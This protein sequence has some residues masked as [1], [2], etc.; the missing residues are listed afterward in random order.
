MSDDF[1][2]RPWTEEPDEDAPPESWLTLG[3]DD[4]LHRIETLD[5]RESEDVRL[6]EVVASDRHFFIRQEAAKRIRSRKLLFPFEDD[7]HVGQILVRH[8][9]RRE[10]L[11]YLERLV[12]RSR[13]VE[14]RKAAQIQLVR[15]RQRL[16]DRAR[17]QN[18]ASRSLI[19]SDPWRV[20]VVYDDDEVRRL[21]VDTLPSLEFAVRAC[22]RNQTEII[23][24][25]DP[26]L[27]LVGFDDL[28]AEPRLHAALHGT[29]RHAPIV[30]LCSPQQVDRFP[31]ARS[32]GA[33]DFLSLPIGATLLDAKTRALLHLAHMAHSRSDAFKAVGEL[34]PEG[35]VPLFRL[36]EDEGLSCRL[37]VTTADRRLFADFV[38]GEMAEAGA[39]PPLPEED[40]FA[41]LLAAREGRYEIIEATTASDEQTAEEAM[42]ASI[43]SVISETETPPSPLPEPPQTPPDRDV[44]ATLLG[45]AIHFVVE[46]AWG[47]LGTAVTCGLLKRTLQET[48]DRYP[49]VGAFAVAEN[50]HVQVNLGHGL[51]L[52]ASAVEG[53]ANWMAAFLQSA[54]RIAHEVGL[55]EVRAIT[56]LVGAALEQVGFY[57]A[58]ERASATSTPTFGSSARPF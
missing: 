27:L 12:D 57:E 14:V 20:A 26:D 46:G 34:G 39:V 28:L 33:D 53:V 56:K 4:L 24:A 2:R 10:D 32:R 8:L 43:Q 23:E 37:A 1:S 17:R 6:L 9:T 54:R 3:D 45:W 13:H 50:A 48:M 16:A 52:P 30:V 42:A 35:V 40:A 36:C 19:D 25:F 55:V 22:D 47:H 5:P 31:E 11:T 44:D 18:T 7:R 51:R 58:Y 49:S 21:V 41:A 38:E 15:L 29:E